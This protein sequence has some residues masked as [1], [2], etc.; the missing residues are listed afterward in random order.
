M[1]KLQIMKRST[2]EVFTD[3]LS[4]FKCS[5]RL[6]AALLLQFLLQFFLLLTA[7]NFLPFM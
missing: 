5:H 7:F 2:G 1:G 6:F 4:G 3:F